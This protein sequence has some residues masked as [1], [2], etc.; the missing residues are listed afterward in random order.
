MSISPKT[1][2]IYV[3]KYQQ[4]RRQ[5]AKAIGAQIETSVDPI[6]IVEYL[7]MRKPDLAKR[8]WRL[9]KAA[10]DHQFRHARDTAPDQASQQEI[11]YALQILR[12]ESQEG[13]LVRGTRTSAK[14]ARQIRPEDFATLVSYIA[15]HQDDHVRARALLTWCVATEP[16]GLRPA[17]WDGAR[18]DTGA[19]GIPLLIVQNAKATNGRGNGP[20]RTLDLS[21]CSPAQLDAVDELLDLIEGYRQ[22]GGFERFQSQISEYLYRAGRAALSKRTQYPSL[23]TFRHQFSA[24]AKSHLSRSEVAALMGH[25]SDATASRNY[26]QSRL[27][28]GQV[29]VRPLAAEVGRVRRQGHDRPRTSPHNGR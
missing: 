6:R 28:T 11:D 9:Y 19:D 3:T 23:Y 16:V 1:E 26:A 22:D 21:A 25:A 29:P 15:R 10:L 7:I 12:A 8:T 27:A 14:K 20:T 18:R 24:N 17:E 2:S 13:A 4:L 5:T